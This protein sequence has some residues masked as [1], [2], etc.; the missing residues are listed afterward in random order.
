M[1]PTLVSLPLC[2]L[3]ACSGA[4]GVI[5]Q[6]PAREPADPGAAAPT[7][8]DRGLAWLAAHQDE[9]GRW[10]CDGFGK[11]DGDPDAQTAGAGSPIHDV[12]ATGLALLAFLGGGSTLRAG[13]YKRQVIEGTRWLLNQQDEET[14]L[15]G[16]AQ[17]HDFIYGHAIASWALCEAYG[18]SNLRRIKKNAQRALNYL[19]KHRNPYGVWRYQ[20]RDGD[21]DTSVTTWCVMAYCAGRDFG[22][23]VNE[24]A[25]QIAAAYYDQVTDPATGRHGYT[26]RGERSS[27]MPGEHS[28]RFPIRKNEALTGAGLF[29]R[30]MLGQQPSEHPVMTKAAALLNTC[31]PAWTPEAGNIDLYAWYWASLALFQT[32]GEAWRTW[33]PALGAAL[34]AGQRQDGAAAGSWDPVSV[35][36]ELS[37]RVGS[38]AMATLA[39]QTHYRYSRLVR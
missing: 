37:G 14:G 31:P 1:H 11:H 3:A 15:I 34:A 13:P 18:L 21:S 27:R 25:L 28:R 32:G 12:G 38:T 17:S 30:F 9:D 7:A 39:L 29:A 4:P 2:L 23:E 33:S 16:T 24:Q 26:K 5:E 36:S 8:V 35:W 6:D 19:E 10:D 22:L 20:P